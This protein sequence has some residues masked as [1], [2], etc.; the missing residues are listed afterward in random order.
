[1]L[2]HPLIVILLLCQHKVQDWQL[3]L[4]IVY[5]SM[6]VMQIQV[7]CF[8]AHRYNLILSKQIIFS[9]YQAVKVVILQ[10]WNPITIHYWF[11]EKMQL[12]WCAVIQ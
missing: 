9:I 3:V 10:L 5:L 11:S 1:M 8:S 2:L 6:V 4:R 7:V 12:I